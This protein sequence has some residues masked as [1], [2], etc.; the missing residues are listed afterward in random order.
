VIINAIVARIQVKE[1]ENEKRVIITYGSAY[2]FFI[3]Y[4]IILF[5]LFAF[6]VFLFLNTIIRSDYQLTINLIVAL[7]TGSILAIIF[8]L[9]LI[10]AAFYFRVVLIQDKRTKDIT[11]LRH[12]IEDSDP[13]VMKK[14]DNPILAASHSKVIPSIPNS[15]AIMTKTRSE[16]LH[17]FRIGRDSLMNQ[18]Y[19]KKQY[20]MI[21][22]ELDIP[23]KK[24]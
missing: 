14:K 17:V 19:T 23:V 7:V 13:V 6:W 3:F 5:L 4:V 20:R 15:V 18:F 1:D 2:I 12:G 24:H 16:P 8:L 10:V 21:A 22:R 11:L 9:L